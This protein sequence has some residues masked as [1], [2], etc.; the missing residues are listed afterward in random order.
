MPY[1]E[2]E[3][4]IL[5][6]G[7]NGE[8]GLLKYLGNGR[9]GINCVILDTTTTEKL[10]NICLKY[11]PNG[12]SYGCG[13]DGICISNLCGYSFIQAENIYISKIKKHF[14]CGHNLGNDQELQLA[15]KAITG[16]NTKKF[17]ETEK[18]IA[19]KAISEGYV[20]REGDLL[21][22]KILVC[23]ESDLPNLWAI[24]DLITPSLTDMSCK[25]ANELGQ[26]IKETLPSYLLPEYSYAVDIAL[27]PLID[28]TSDAL[29][30]KGY[31]TAPKDGIGAEG[32]FMT[33]VK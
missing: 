18:E 10:H 28:L 32:C 26:T 7:T 1:V 16:L 4:D 13:H 12:K 3:L 27:L 30:E 6:Q 25:L 19:A 11:I 29:I 22:T 17:T 8:Y 9:Y 20:Y 15:I 33:V 5:T 14:S 24:N 23:K 31:L 2:E 21:Y